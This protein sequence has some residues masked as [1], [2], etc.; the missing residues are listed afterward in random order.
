MLPIVSDNIAIAVV[1]AISA[2]ML[3]LW[4]T[5]RET[6]KGLSMPK[7]D[8]AMIENRFEHLEH[9]VESIAIEIE[10]VSEG[11]RYVTKLMTDRAQPSL[12][13]AKAPVPVQT[14]RMDTPH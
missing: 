11:Q 13:A 7:Q 9:A 12:D 4:L 5:H 2:V 1:F 3:K 10:R 8:R 6:M 14:R